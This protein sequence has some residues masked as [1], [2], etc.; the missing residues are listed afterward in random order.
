MV[1]RIEERGGDGEH[2]GKPCRRP[3]VRH[4]LSA[5]VLIDSGTRGEGVYSRSDA[6]LPLR[7]ARP[8]AC[9]PK[10]LRDH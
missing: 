4:V 8:Q 3:D 1:L 2:A 7:D 5:F 10:S 9:L 6:E